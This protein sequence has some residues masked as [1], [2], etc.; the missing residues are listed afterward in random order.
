MFFVHGPNEDSLSL[1]PLQALKP[2]TQRPRPIATTVEAQVRSGARPERHRCSLDRERK[3]NK[4]TDRQTDDL[5]FFF[6]RSSH[7]YVVYAIILFISNE[8][9]QVF[10]GILRP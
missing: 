3:T 9:T 6:E 4:Q 10:L 7:V 2:W 8:E 5:Q 1:S